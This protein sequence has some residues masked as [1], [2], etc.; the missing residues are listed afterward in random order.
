MRH[1]GFEPTDDLKKHLAA[2]IMWTP[3]GREFP[4]PTFELGMAPAGSMYSTVNDLAIFLKMLAAGGKGVIDAKSLEQM[5][6]PQFAKPDTKTGVGLG[7]FIS[8]HHGQRKLRHDGAMY[9]FATELAFLPEEKLGVVVAI[10]CDCAN[11]VAERIAN[12]A[13]DL[14]LAVKHDKPLPAL[15]ATEPVPAALMAKLAGRWET[16]D[17]KV[18]LD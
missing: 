2:G 8:E 1:S 11:P 3:H 18:A 12:T 17:G 14:R 15:P 6:T 5:W 13:L 7:F 4:A 9:G 10:S 16:A